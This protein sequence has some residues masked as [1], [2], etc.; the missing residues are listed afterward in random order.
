MAKKYIDVMD[1]TFRD[2][3]QSVFGGRVLMDDF[4]PAVEAAKNAGINHFEF[5]GGARFQSLFFYLQENAFEMMDGFREIVGPDANLQVLSRG[6]NTVMLD[7]GSREMIE[8]FAKMFKKHGTTTV[9]N[10]D[11]LNDVNNLAFSAEMIKKHGLDHEVVVTMMD[12]PPGCKGAHDV[13]FYEKTLRNILDSGIS[14]DSVCFKDASGTANPHKVYETIAMA[15]KL[16][17]D[18]VHLRLHTH[19]TAGVSVA[20]YLAA[21]DAGANGIDMAA[22]PVSGG[23]SQPDILTMLHATKGTDYNLGDLQ[24]DKIL[25]YEERLKEC[26]SDYMI[27]PEATQVSPLIPFS[28]MP[29]GALTA[30]TQMMRDSGDLEKFDEVIGAMKEVVERGGYGTSVTPVSQFYWQQAYA[31]VMFGPWKQIAPGYGRMVLG[32]FGKTPVQA[33]E[34]I[35]E[36]ASKKL[37]LEPTTENPLDIADRDETKSIAH[38]TK[39]LEDEGLETSDENIFIAGACAEKGIAFLKGESPL[40]V[41]KND[42]NISNGEADMAGNYTVVVDGKQYSVQVAE[43]EGDIQIAP[44]TPAQVN[45]VAESATPALVPGAAGS[46]EVHSQTPGNVWKIVKNPGDTVAE[47]DVIMILEAMKMEIDIAAPKAG[48]IASINV[49]VNDSVADGQLLATME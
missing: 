44:A 11:A 24:L 20:S 49:N 10:F 31:N 18:S 29:G 3:F 28:P 32:Y 36:L 23:T 25:K 1:T 33:D 13:A 40:M 16:L 14:Y 5:G 37:D 26:L 27:P 17:G 15:R 8:L 46:V 19:E 12:L 41:R 2:G 43:G 22:S 21:L 38:W 9:R 39:V 4:F 35:I 34:E 7:T 30:N 6:I 45:A 42:E 47:G 48:K